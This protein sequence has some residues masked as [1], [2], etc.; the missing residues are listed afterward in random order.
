MGTDKL[1]VPKTNTFAVQPNILPKFRSRLHHDFYK[2]VYNTSRFISES[3]VEPYEYPVG[4]HDHIRTRCRGPP[5]PITF[6]TYDSRTRTET[7]LQQ[8]RRRFSE[9]YNS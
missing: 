6:D 1:F 3:Q 7:P 9:I 4:A 8:A 2:H 5:E